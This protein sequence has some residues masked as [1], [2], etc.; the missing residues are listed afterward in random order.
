[1]NPC[2]PSQDIVESSV[3]MYQHSLVVL[4][5]PWSVASAQEVDDKNIFFQVS[6]FS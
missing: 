1:M 2:H 6:I 5:L 4:V 3:A